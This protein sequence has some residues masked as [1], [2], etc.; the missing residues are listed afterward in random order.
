[1]SIKVSVIVPT[2]NRPHF[3]GRTIDSLLAQTYR[4]TEIV[5]VDDNAPDSP[6]RA[7]TQALM[8]E[9][10]KYDNVIYIQNEK[11]L[12]GGPSRNE[13]IKAATGDYVT[14]LDDDDVYLPEKVETQLSFMLK[15]DLDMSFTDVFI[16]KADGKLIEYR[17]HNYVND[18]SNEALFRQ[19]ILH[20]LCPTSTYMIKRSFILS[21]DGFRAVPMGQDFWLM[22]DMLEHNAKTGY[23]PVSYIIQYI[24]NEG[25]ISL[26]KNKVN[27]EKALYELK[28][29]KLDLLTAKERRYVRF[30]H[31]AVLTVAYKR[32]GKPLNAIYYGIRT[33][34]ASPASVIKEFNQLLINRRMAK[35]TINA[36]K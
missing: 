30:R 16:H 3:L 34:V 35:Q 20:S 15:N 22:W 8:K 33:V 24:H 19:H 27:G 25:R 17:R 5:V 23:F 1:M 13:G 18:C 32:S 28:K 29:T 10:E 11:P 9:Y 12:G 26:G 36:G 21:T 31:Y 2:H 4:D 14:F 6:S 7:D